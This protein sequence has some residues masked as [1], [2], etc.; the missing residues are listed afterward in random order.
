MSRLAF[1]EEEEMPIIKKLGGHVFTS[2]DN[3]PEFV[4][5]RYNLTIFVTKYENTYLCKVGRSEDEKE[6]PVVVSANGRNI[7]DAILCG[8][9]AMQR[10]MRPYILADAAAKFIEDDI[11]KEFD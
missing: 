4:F 2:M 8:M 1:D 6:M 10:A 7:P 3:K 5:N 11:N 9:T